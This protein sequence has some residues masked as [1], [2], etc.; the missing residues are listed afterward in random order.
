M[1]PI[2][3][4]LESPSAEPAVP[5]TDAGAAPETVVAEGTGVGSLL[6]QIRAADKSATETASP[7]SSEPQE[8]VVEQ[9]PEQETGAEGQE[10]QEEKKPELTQG[11]I[12]ESIRSLIKKSNLPPERKDELAS[13]AYKGLQL[14]KLGFDYDQVK[15]L[16]EMAVTP[17]VI[18]DRVRLHPTLEDAKRDAMYAE[19]MRELIND[20]TTQ[21]E[22][23]ARKLHATSPETFRPLALDI[24]NNIDKIAP[25][26]AQEAWSRKFSTVLSRVEKNAQASQNVDLQAAVAM[27]RDHIYGDTQ[28]SKPDPNDP[29]VQENTRLRAIFENQQR[30]QKQGMEQARSQFGNALQNYGA[31]AIFSDIKTALEAQKPTGMDA[32]L[33]ERTV[34][35]VFN[36][37]TQDLLSN[38]NFMKDMA[39]FAQGNPTQE[40]LGAAIDFAR[41][42]A[43]VLMA[44]HLRSALGKWG[45]Y[46]LQR[47]QTTATTQAKAAS[48]PDVGKATGPP[49]PAAGVPLHERVLAEGKAKNLTPLEMMRMHDSLRRAG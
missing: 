32:D 17:E 11:Q 47:A 19:D 14:T 36:G 15:F 35:D 33:A 23:A 18:L 21:P 37:V 27:L 13:L 43:R 1:D 10:S 34:G 9:K 42:R 22:V 28:T 29:V 38:T 24:F 7:E 39:R 25:D 31:Q 8:Q 45:K 12:E 5:V 3:G 46:A 2:T 40:Q 48:R 49:T 6:D 30:Q 41:A 4:A 20:L 16:K 44:P 26:V